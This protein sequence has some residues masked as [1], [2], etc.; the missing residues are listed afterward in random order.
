M[1]SDPERSSRTSRILL[2]AGAAVAIISVV[3]WF[4][5]HSGH[6]T[7]DSSTAGRCQV[8]SGATTG[9]EP[10]PALVDLLTTSLG[11][12][13]TTWSKSSQ[14]TTVYS[15]CYNSVDGQHVNAAIGLLSGH[16][17]TQAPGNDPTSQTN[18]TKPG[19][20][21]Y[22]VSLNVTADLDV[23]HLDP[24]AKGGLSIVWTDTALPAS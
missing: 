5:V 9:T 17:Y 14:G 11:P 10:L 3:T 24:L 2:I 18:F 19:S 4:T 12:A 16:G 15:Y 7:A 8:P 13:S 23:S 1:M 6:E 22:G 21:P 20:T